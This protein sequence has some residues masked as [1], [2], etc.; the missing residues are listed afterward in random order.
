MAVTQPIGFGTDATAETVRRR[1]EG[2]RLDV[3]GAVFRVLIAAAL[4]ISL[5]VLAVLLVDVVSGGWSVLSGRLGEF[6][7]GD[8]V[9]SAE[10][11]GIFQGLRGSFWIG[12][13]TVVLAF[14]I[15]IG[16]AIYLEE[17]APRNTFTRFIDINIRN[18]AGVPSIVFGILGFAI[19]VKSLALFPDWLGGGVFFG[20]RTVMAAGVTLAILVLPIVIITSAEAIRAVPDSIREAGFGVGATR[21]EVVRAHVLPYAAPGILTGTVLS[22]ARALGEAAPLILVGAVTGRLGQQTGFL[23]V[24]QLQER[25][26][27][28]PIVITEWAGTPQQGFEA[29]TAAAIVVLLVVV[30]LANTAAILLRNRYEKRR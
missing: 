22:L 6:L 8:L 24:G 2:K 15:G 4:G 12:V 25:F 27:A 13:F 14:P 9:T 17:Y 16:A 29:L 19:F 20:G 3:N 23:D 30:L 5:V 11:A 26:T 10:E 28:M 1:L 21:W 18:L 7:A